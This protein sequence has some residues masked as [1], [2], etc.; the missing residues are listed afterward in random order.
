MALRP[1]SHPLVKLMDKLVP[2]D[3]ETEEEYNRDELSALVRI[4][5]EERIQAQKQRDMTNVLSEQGVSAPPHGARRRSRIQ[6]MANQLNAHKQRKNYDDY[7]STRR[8]RQLKQEIMTSVA[9]RMSG[10][11]D[12]A[13]PTHHKRVSSG[14]LQSLLEHIPSLRRSTSES[15][16]QVDSITP[17]HEQIA[18]PLERTEVRAIEGAL[19][20]KTM[21]ALDVYTPLRMIFAVPED[22]VLTQQAFA[23]IFSQGYSRVPV[24]ESR[25]SS[26][27][28]KLTAMKGVLM[29]RQLI[30]VDWVDERAVS[31]LPLYIPPCVSPRMNLVSLLHLL[32]KG[33]SLIAFVCAGEWC[34][35]Y[36]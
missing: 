9:E 26:G 1:F 12:N 18:P 16:T 35:I 5:Y 25:S 22:L 7:K 3:N 14:G 19:N 11:T 27:E 29:T 2:E 23:E 20:L 13:S 36:I 10:Q 31:T 28:N 21:C 4:Q 32:R 34:V 8:W 15:I 17:A 24:Y 6:H 33:G 30:M